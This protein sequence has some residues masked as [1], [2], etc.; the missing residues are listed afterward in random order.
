MGG[1]SYDRAGRRP[2]NRSGEVDLAEP[3]YGTACSPA[4]PSRP[5]GFGR[6]A[7]R[8]VSEFFQRAARKTSWAEAE[9]KGATAGPGRVSAPDSGSRPGQTHERLAERAIPPCASF[10]KLALHVSRGHNRLA[11]AS[12]SRRGGGPLSR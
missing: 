7:V 6:E 2:R 11:R 5:H 9:P 12:R 4:K 10:S 8:S 3:G 1:R